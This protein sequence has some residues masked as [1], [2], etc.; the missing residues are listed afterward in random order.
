[1]VYGAVAI[2]FILCFQLYWLYSLYSNQEKL[3]VEEAQNKLTA[4]SL[5]IEGLEM[6]KNLTVNGRVDVKDSSVSGVVKDSNMVTNLKVEIFKTAGDGKK[7]PLSVTLIDSIFGPESQKL[8]LE[9]S[10]NETVKTIKKALP[11]VDFILYD[12]KVNPESGRVL[13]SSSRL[14]TKI[15]PTLVLYNLE[16]SVIKKILPSIGLSVLYL[17]VCVSAVVLLI[18]SIRKSRRLMEQKVSFTNN[19]THELKTP[20]ATLYA[21]TE[22][23]DKYNVLEDK[24][25]A[26]EYVHLMQADLKRLKSMADSI[27]HNARLSEGKIQLYTEN[28]HLKHLL[29]EVVS[30]LRPRLEQLEAVITCSIP[31][32]LYIK[33][34]EDHISRIFINLI[35][36]SL[37]YAVAIPQISITAVRDGNFIAVD[38]T[39]NGIGIPYKYHKDIFRPYFRVS[40]GNRHTVKGYG[41]GLSYV[42]EVLKLHGGSIVLIKDESQKGT[43]FKILIPTGHE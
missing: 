13:R 21:A 32:D 37:K 18:N 43:A 7:M 1:M 28:L 35:D 11:G 23:L 15:S 8:K 5:D 30:N 24:K 41:L 40:E 20:I 10:Y 12:R 22:A 25:T 14:K 26:R 9:K 2:L 27:L 19:M 4:Y 6:F 16:Y 17:L 42:K 38:L 31:D 36:N 34:D 3:I 29:D 33:A 39:D